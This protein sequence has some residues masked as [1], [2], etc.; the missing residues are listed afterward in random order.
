[1][2][3]KVRSVSMIFNHQRFGNDILA[4]RLEASIPA[5]DTAVLTGLA[6]TTVTRYERGEEPNMKIGHFLLLCNVYD[7]DPREYFELER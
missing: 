1:M 7:L 6:I 3:K 4:S 5:T 2:T